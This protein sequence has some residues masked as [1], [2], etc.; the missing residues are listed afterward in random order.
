MYEIGDGDVWERDITTYYTLTC[1]C[2]WKEG[3]NMKYF[4]VSS[5]LW[6]CAWKKE[7]DDGV[8]SGRW[9]SWWKM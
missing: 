7:D 8:K 6:N 2:E 1:E 9:W 5:F 3:K 4:F